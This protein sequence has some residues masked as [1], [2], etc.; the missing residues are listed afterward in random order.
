MKKSKIAAGVVV[1]LAAV[2]CT[3]AWF[4]GKKA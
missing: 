2:W 3:S 4:T 1:A